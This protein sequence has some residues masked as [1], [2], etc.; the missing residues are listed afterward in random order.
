MGFR[1]RFCSHHFEFVRTGQWI[2]WPEQKPYS[3]HCSLVHSLDPIRGIFNSTWSRAPCIHCPFHQRLFGSTLGTGKFMRHFTILMHIL[4][5]LTEQYAFS[6]T[7]FQV[8]AKK[9]K[10]VLIWNTESTT[11]KKVNKRNKIIPSPN[12][13]S[14]WW[15]QV[16]L[17]LICG[18][19]RI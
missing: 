15:T 10:M 19:L 2:H 6:K 1:L 5:Y 8:K 11:Q 16:W 17:N 13:Y 4:G 12:L 3:F 9:E 14:T 7:L 18:S